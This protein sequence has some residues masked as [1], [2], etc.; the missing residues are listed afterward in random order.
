[1][2]R[3][4]GILNNV[5]TAQSVLDAALLLKQRFRKG[6]I[7]VVHPRPEV[8]PDFMPTEEVWTDE[9]RL[10]FERQR[11]Q[12][13]EDLNDIY[14]GWSREN[15]QPAQPLQQTVGKVEHVVAQRSREA[16]LERVMH[17]ASGLRH[18]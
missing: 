11:D 15:G 2:E 17:L 4:L 12:L 6:Q 5:E 10:A 1:M 14:R 18:V 8:A 13:Y 16:D 7:E 3:L 9:K